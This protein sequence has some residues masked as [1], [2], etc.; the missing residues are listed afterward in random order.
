M[1]RDVQSRDLCFASYASQW[2]LADQRRVI[3]VAGETRDGKLTKI[4]ESNP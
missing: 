2:P 1:P 4:G 3:A